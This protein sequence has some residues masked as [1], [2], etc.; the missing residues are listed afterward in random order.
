MK[1]RLH[2]LHI[3]SVVFLP[4]LSV[5]QTPANWKVNGNAV[6][7]GDF[8]GTTNNQPLIFYSN[9]TEW[10]RLNSTGELR[11]NYLSSTGNSFLTANSNGELRKILYSNDSNQVLTGAGT[12]RTGSSFGPWSKNGSNVF[13]TSVNVGI[14]T[15]TPQYLLDV[16]GSAHF[17][18]TVFANGITLLNSMEA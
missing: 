9:N 7:T 17:D 15:N 1:F 5:A 18:G 6:A 16:S 13:I 14:G 4:L 10:M 3:L 11:I 8:L 2:F 12:F